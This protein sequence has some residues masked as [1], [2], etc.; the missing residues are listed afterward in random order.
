MRCIYCPVQSECITFVISITNVT[1]RTV[2]WLPHEAAAG[3]FGDAHTTTG[4]AVLAS[5]SGIGTVEMNQYELERPVT[6]NSF[7]EQSCDDCIIYILPGKRLPSI[8][9]CIN[10]TQP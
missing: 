8:T 7:L 1:T 9:K 2:G 6:C 5:Q 4:R 10:M 3:S